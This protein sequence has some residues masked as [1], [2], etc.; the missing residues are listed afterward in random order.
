M[1]VLATGREGCARLLG[2]PGGILRREP[3]RFVL[4]RAKRTVAIGSNLPTRCEHLLL[5]CC[6]VVS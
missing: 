4:A 1:M 2:G 3:R 5:N 6:Q